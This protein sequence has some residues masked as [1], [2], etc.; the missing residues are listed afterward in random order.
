M[1]AMSANTHCN[2]ADDFETTEERGWLDLLGN[3]KLASWDCMVYPGCWKDPDYRLARCHSSRVFVPFILGIHTEYSYIS[4]II[5]SN[6]NI[7][8]SMLRL[9]RQQ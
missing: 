2:G 9:G 5:P 8:R 3:Y 4:M 7:T 1:L 6:H